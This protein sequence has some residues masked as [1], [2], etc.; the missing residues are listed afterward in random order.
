MSTHF[1]LLLPENDPMHE[2]HMNMRGAREVRGAVLRGFLCN[3]ALHEFRKA[4]EANT[5]RNVGLDTIGVDKWFMSADVLTAAEYASAADYLFFAAG[6]LPD[7]FERA[8]WRDAF[9]LLGG[10]FRR[11]SQ[12]GGAVIILPPAAA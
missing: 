2:A 11:A 7:V 9:L 12:I 10:L 1:V 4:L 6:A 3:K 8:V 5:P